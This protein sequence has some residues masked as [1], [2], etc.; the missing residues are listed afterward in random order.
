MKSS[1][2]ARAA[3]K[4]WMPWRLACQAMEF[5]AGG[6]EES[7][8]WEWE[9]DEGEGAGWVEIMMERGIACGIRRIGRGK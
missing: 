6:G 8:D 9:W 2:S 1:G 5:S 7:E 3:I 4:F